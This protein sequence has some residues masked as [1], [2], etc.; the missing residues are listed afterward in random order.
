MVCSRMFGF[1]SNSE[2]QDHRDR[3]LSEGRHEV[4]IW[5]SYGVQVRDVSMAHL[6]VDRCTRTIWSHSVGNCNKLFNI[7]R[8]LMWVALNLPI[9][10]WFNQ[11]WYAAEVSES[12]FICPAQSWQFARMFAIAF[13]KHGSLATWKG[14]ILSSGK[15]ICQTESGYSRT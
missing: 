4:G 14:I 8:K 15:N 2:V 9:Y 7:N 12:T 13:G 10:L 5:S 11:S 1:C 6:M 3:V